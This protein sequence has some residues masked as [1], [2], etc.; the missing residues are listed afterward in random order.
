VWFKG[1]R[2][3]VV[4]DP[5]PARKKIKAQARLISAVLLL[6]GKEKGG[7]EER[8]GTEQVFR[9]VAIRRHLLR[10]RPIEGDI[11]DRILEGQQWKKKKKKTQG[12]RRVIF[13][14]GQRLIP[15]TGEKR[16]GPT[17]R[18]QARYRKL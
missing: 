10:G 18:K 6:P 11:I 16:K 17:K 2:L 15:L 9:K 4:I 8:G 12:R 13:S 3:F 5:T 14:A 1:I 7:K